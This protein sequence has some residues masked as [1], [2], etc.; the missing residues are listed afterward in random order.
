VHQQRQPSATLGY[1][2]EQLDLIREQGSFNQ[3]EVAGGQWCYASLQVQGPSPPPRSPPPFV[4]QLDSR[5]G[6]FWRGL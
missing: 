5:K 6:G 1:L 3:W 2:C 4:S